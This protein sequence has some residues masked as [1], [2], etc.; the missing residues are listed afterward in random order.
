[1]AN[2]NAR[3]S[4]GEPGETNPP[5]VVDAAR[6]RGGDALRA[7]RE[8]LAAARRDGVVGNPATLA[9]RPLGRVN[10]S[11][12]KPNSEA[13]AGL[14]TRENRAFPSSDPDALD[15]AAAS[16]SES[17]SRSETET[18][19]FFFEDD[20]RDLDGVGDVD[21][22]SPRFRMGGEPREPPV[23]SPSP[24]DRPFR[25]GEGLKA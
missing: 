22:P 7:L 1:M 17:T 16:E 15:D 10:V 11:V 4:A 20:A 3:D 24:G 6:R 18:R 13:D 14:V 5:A 19:A 21:G 12:R 25:E 9:A 23:R 8:A 2:A